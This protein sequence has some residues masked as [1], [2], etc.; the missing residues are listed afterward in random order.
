MVVALLYQFRKV[1]NT[2]EEITGKDKIKMILFECPRFL[3][4]IYLKATIGRDP[5]MLDRISLMSS[6]AVNLPTRLDR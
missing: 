5:F 2:Q 3:D 6:K 1:S 4:I